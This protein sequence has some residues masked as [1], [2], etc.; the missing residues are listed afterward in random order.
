M[1]TIE[2]N[3]FRVFVNRLLANPRISQKEK[4]AYCYLL[5]Y[6]LRE[7]KEYCGFKYLYW[8]DK[9]CKEWKAAGE[10]E[11]PEKSKYLGPE[12]DRAYY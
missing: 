12:Y 11:F 9:G 10:P 1:A 5:E 8:M 4:E 3:S 2:L 7:A 6:Y